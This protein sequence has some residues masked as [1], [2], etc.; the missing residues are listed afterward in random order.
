MI[1][2]PSGIFLNVSWSNEATNFTFTFHFHALEKEMATHSSV[3]AWRIP[4]TRSLGGLPPMGSHRVRH[5][6]SGL[7]AAVAAWTKWNCF[8]C[9]LEMVEYQQFHVVQSNNVDRL[10]SLPAPLIFSSHFSASDTTCFTISPLEYKLCEGY[11]SH[12]SCLPVYPQNPPHYLACGCSV[13]SFW[14]IE[15]TWLFEGRRRE[16]IVSV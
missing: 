7:A 11:R 8:F 3:L 10:K 12:I 1:S 2:S 6:W 13:S 5:D 16:A 9:K 15:R 14:V 4:G